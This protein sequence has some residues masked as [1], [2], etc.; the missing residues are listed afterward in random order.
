M[1]A[2]I[3]WKIIHQVLIETITEMMDEQQTIDVPTLRSR[4]MEMAESESD[5]AMV[6]CYWQASKVLM[7]LPPTVTAS[8]LIEEARVA[9]R[10]PLNHDRL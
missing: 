5:E 1:F 7:R 6:L 2:N 9:Y 3:S 8:Q 4:L 10:T